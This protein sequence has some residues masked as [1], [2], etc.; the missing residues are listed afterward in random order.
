MSLLWGFIYAYDAGI[1]KGANGIWYGT[2]IKLFNVLSQKHDI[3]LR[4]PRGAIDAVGDTIAKR[5]SSLSFQGS[6][7]IKEV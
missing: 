5:V 2:Y 7:T 3:T 6:Q 4:S 1:N